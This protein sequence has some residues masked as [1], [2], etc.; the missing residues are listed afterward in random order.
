MALQ[1]LVDELRKEVE[2]NKR[3]EHYKTGKFRVYFTFSEM[4]QI[5]HFF[6]V[7]QIKQ[8]TQY[9]RSIKRAHKRDSA[10]VGG[11]TEKMTATVQE[12]KLKKDLNKTIKPLAETI[13]KRDGKKLIT[14]AH[15]KYKY[16]L[17]NNETQLENDM[18]GV[19]VD[20]HK[21]VFKY[22]LAVHGDRIEVIY[23]RSM[24][25][26]NTEVKKRTGSGA[27]RKA[28]HKEDDVGNVITGRVVDQFLDMVLDAV[29]KDLPKG[30]GKTISGITPDK[31]LPG[32]YSPGQL[33]RRRPYKGKLGA[34]S[35]S[36]L[37]IR[38]HGEPMGNEDPIF[39]ADT[40]EATANLLDLFQ[41]PAKVTNLKTK[42]LAAA[43]KK[44]GK[45]GK[46]A[47][48]MKKIYE[49]TVH[50]LLTD[51]KIQGQRMSDAALLDDEYDII[52]SVT[53]EDV[54]AKQKARADKGPI[55]ERIKVVEQ[56]MIDILSDPASI[57]SKPMKDRLSA[58]AAK[59]IIQNMFLHKTNPDMRFKVNKKLIAEGKYKDNG[60]AKGK[61]R[62]KK[63]KT[64]KSSQSGGNVP[65]VALDVA[66]V[67]ATAKIASRGATTRTVKA[68]STNPMALRNLLNAALPTAVARNMQSPRL[69]FR[70]G[71]L[72]NSVRVDDITTGPRGG[73]MQVNASYQTDPYGTYAPGGK[74]YTPQRNPETLISTSIRQVATGII[75]QRFNVKV[76]R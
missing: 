34:R 72:A 69:R 40:T 31:D 7:D 53:I 23:C 33:G 61:A 15:K 59:N 42:M 49:D 45:R 5:A 17:A 29:T 18:A 51:L 6:I 28:L 19:A 22:A 21:S 26:P 11:I 16:V 13:F 71:R 36:G 25:G 60:T 10:L 47:F 73:N 20:D 44:T 30:R 54:N 74:R 2:K 48:G 70:T 65:K 41:D 37:R 8:T 62:G 32:A 52:M 68:A 1:V 35:H 12:T 67:S 24:F 14:K 63:G 64:Q 4:A 43:K 46:P 39:G 38:A 56:K 50:H 75:G 3:I 58:A 76:D 57:A 66:G 9:K 27:H 55:V